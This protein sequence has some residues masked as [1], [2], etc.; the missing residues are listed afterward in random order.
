MNK[1]IFKFQKEDPNKIVRSFFSE[2]EKMLINGA[3]KLGYSKADDKL[4][5]TPWLTQDDKDI[6][7]RLKTRAVWFYMY[8]LASKGKIGCDFTIEY[9]SDHTTR[10]LLGRSEDKKSCFTVNQTSS[11]TRSS[12][13]AKYRAERHKNFESYFDLWDEGDLITEAPLYFELNHGYQGT[14]PNF[15][16]FGIPDNN[17]RWYASEQLLTF[18]SMQMELDTKP[19]KTKA[20]DVPDFSESE[21][22]NFMKELGER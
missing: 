19:F 16:I 22:E 18:G 10:F 2:K 20:E 1:D 17:Q 15:V 5:S 7:A 14:S 21:F 4:K 11:N 13:Y 8:S 6:S 12:R 3:V 9:N